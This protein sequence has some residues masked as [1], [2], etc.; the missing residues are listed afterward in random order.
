MINMI[1]DSTSTEDRRYSAS[2]RDKRGCNMF[3][4]LQQVDGREMEC[5]TGHVSWNKS[6]MWGKG[7]TLYITLQRGWRMWREGDDESVREVK[8]W[9]GS[10][11][12]AE[13]R[14]MFRTCRITAESS[15]DCECQGRREHEVVSVWSLQIYCIYSNQHRTN[16]IFR[17]WCE[18]S[19]VLKGQMSYFCSSNWRL[20]TST[21]F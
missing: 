6:S 2:C 18:C 8:D 9:R 7:Q 17:F 14:H 20:I 1:Y 15:A 11:I 13:D 21:R 5:V 12:R 16:V 10:A 19:H 4:Q 3:R